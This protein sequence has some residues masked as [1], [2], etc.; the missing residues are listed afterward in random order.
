MGSW[1]LSSAARLRDGRRA[2]KR[3]LALAKRVARLND[4]LLAERLYRRVL[5]I[6]PQHADAMSGIA[7]VC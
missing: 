6:E 5:L 3:N 4:F 1:T 2:P 7:G